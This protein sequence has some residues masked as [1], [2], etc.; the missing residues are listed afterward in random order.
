MA[1][2]DL[3]LV[4]LPVRAPEHRLMRRTEE[5]LT[6]KMDFIPRMI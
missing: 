5:A 2:K 6:F 4:A 1:I 3:Y